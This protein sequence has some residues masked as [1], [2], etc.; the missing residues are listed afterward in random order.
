[1]S[2]FKLTSTGT[3][4][5]IAQLAGHA[6]SLGMSASVDPVWDA[7]SMST[8][9]QAKTS[10]KSKKAGAPHGK[11][12][13]KGKLPVK[14]R[15]PGT[16]VARVASILKTGNAHSPGPFRAS[17]IQKVIISVGGKGNSV[18]YYLRSLVAQK[19]LRRTGKG[20]GTRYAVVP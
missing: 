18:S 9:R 17:D 15:K 12:P 6:I 20:S 2:T 13:A 5:Q 19:V 10:P 1:M 4:D 11:T 7:K 8:Q 3:A 16:N 14:G